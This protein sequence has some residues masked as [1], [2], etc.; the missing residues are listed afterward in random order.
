MPYMQDMDG[1]LAIFNFLIFQ[2]VFNFNSAK[3]ENSCVYCVPRNPEPQQN[4]IPT[5]SCPVHVRT[6]QDRSEIP[7]YCNGINRNRFTILP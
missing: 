6:V 5:H 7:V 4:Q 3:T 1:L 2:E